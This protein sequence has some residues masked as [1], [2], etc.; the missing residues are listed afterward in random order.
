MLNLTPIVRPFFRRRAAAAALWADSEGM[1]RTQRAVLAWLLRRAAATDYGRR[2]GFGQTGRYEDF[3]SA[4]PVVVYE[5]LRAD[6]MRMV[7]GE[8]DVLWP[9]VCRRY[10]QSSGTSGGKS[11][12]IPVTDDSLRA[13]HYAGG[14]SAVAHYLALYP[15]SRLFGGKSFILGGSFANELSG[16]PRDV[17]VGDLS[18]TL[19]DRINPA[20]NMLRVPSKATALMSDWREKLPRL[21]ES[22]INQDITNISGVPSWFM[23]VLRGVMERASTDRIHEVWPNLEV[24]FHGGISFAPYR[25]QYEDFCGPA[26]RFVENYN[27]SEGFFA[28]QDTREGGS[29]RLLADIGVFFEFAPLDGDEPVPAWRV[30]QGRVYSMLISGPN[31]LWRYA[32]GDTVRIENTEPLRISIAGRTQSFIN[33]FGEELMV[34]N[35]DAALAE[36]CRRTGATVANYTAAPVYAECGRKGHHQWLVEWTRRPACGPE[37]FAD[38]LDAELQRVNSDYEAKRAGDIFLARLE[39]TEVPA[40]TFD[41]W[42]SSTGRLGGQRKI[43]RLANDR[44]IADAIIELRINNE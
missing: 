2:Y 4:V 12:Y 5:D 42:L 19:I 3:A 37:A 16:L 13:N 38:V 8:A 31:G 1:E 7:G 30:E 11:K 15:Q 32:I 25:S 22:S 18:A 43:P 20:V 34:W 28:V 17:K 29:M 39:L 10:A 9:G 26:M 36:A 23:T 35:A 41:R 6:V 33:A 27:A 44:R 14:A 21:I 24:F 40:G